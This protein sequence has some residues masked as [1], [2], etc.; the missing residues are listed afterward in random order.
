MGFLGKI[1][2]WRAKIFLWAGLPL[3]A[4]GGI[5]FG[6]LDVVPAWQAHNGAGTA[7]VFTALRE[8][9][10]RRSC[11]FHGSWTA[12]DGGSSRPDVILY[13]EPASL[14]V[15]GTTPA[16]D[17]GAR[18]GVFATAGGPTYLFVTAFLVAGLAAAAGWVFVLRRALRRRRAA[19]A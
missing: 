14:A 12:A 17:S 6:G 9:C 3:I 15:G 16:I 19:A 10:G 11:S 8:E 2:E 7:G 13:D 18:T 4:A 5:I 1:S